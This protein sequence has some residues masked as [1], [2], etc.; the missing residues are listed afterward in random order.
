MHEPSSLNC[1]LSVSSIYTNLYANL[2]FNG[3]YQVTSDS[4]DQTRNLKNIM[5]LGG[6]RGYFWMYVMGFCLDPMPLDNTNERETKAPWATIVQNL[7]FSY[8]LPY[9]VKFGEPR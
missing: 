7:M 4:L 2:S 1:L 8:V 3:Y 9:V 5:Y 6:K